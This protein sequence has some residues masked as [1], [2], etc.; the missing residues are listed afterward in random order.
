M[1][2]IYLP[3]IYHLSLSIFIIYVSSVIYIST[4]LSIHPLYLYPSI[5]PSICPSILC[6]YTYLSNYIIYVSSIIS[7]HP[8]ILCIYI[9]LSIHPLYL[10]LSVYAQSL[11]FVESIS[12][13]SPAR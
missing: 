10:Y 12:E 7:I 4:Y 8:S 13:N 3:S 1:I 9:C 11:L 5:Y 6:V 2:I